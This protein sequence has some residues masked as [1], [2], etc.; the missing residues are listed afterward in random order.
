MNGLVVVDTNVPLTANGV[1]TAS[2]EC[3]RACAEALLE[4]MTDRRA[5]AIDDGWR[6]LREYMGKLR[7][8]GQPGLGD[9]FLKWVLTNRE[10]PLRCEQ[11]T[12]RP[13]GSEHDF[14]EFPG[15]ADLA[16]FDPSDRK[17]VAV[18]AAHPCRPPILEGVDSKW[19]GWRVGLEAAGIRVHFLCPDDVRTTY[20]AKF[21]EP[22]E[23]GRARGD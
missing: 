4:I 3:V 17:L 7:P 14:E 22:G 13:R 21:G 23:R 5:I 8:S 20:E 15:T 6:I 16:A 9:R 10:N 12:I 18:A 11:V 1:A 2:A 19:W